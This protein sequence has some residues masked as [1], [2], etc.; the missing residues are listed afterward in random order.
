MPGRV[1][2]LARLD[3]AQRNVG[4]ET[5][6]LVWMNFGGSGPVLQRRPPAV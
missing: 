2:V 5:V 3:G 1:G 4:R 6:A